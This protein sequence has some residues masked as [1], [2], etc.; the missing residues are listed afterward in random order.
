MG[1]K[2][3]EQLARLRKLSAESVDNTNAFD[4][5]K[6]YIHVER[7]VERELRNLLR[8]L[9]KTPQK[10]LVLLCGSAGDGKSHLLSYLKNVDSEK[11]LEDYELYNDATESSAPNLTSIDT[12]AD[13]LQDYDDEHYLIDDGKKMILAI[14]LGTLSNFIESEKGKR[15]SALKQY[16]DGND[17][18]D[19]FADVESY[20]PTPVFRHINFSD[21]QMFTLRENGVRT[22][23][24]EALLEKVFNREDGTPFYD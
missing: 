13:K 19:G 3:V 4:E 21:Y 7:P 17:I 18:F 9:N 12:L 8:K 1:C 2:F 16:V 20:Q 23:Y 10:R 14:N 15:F 11:L 5:F 6:E 24:L 22:D